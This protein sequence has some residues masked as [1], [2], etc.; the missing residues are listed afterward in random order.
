MSAGQKRLERLRRHL[1][2]PTQQKR[3]AHMR[4]VEQARLAARVVMFG[5][6]SGRILHRHLVAGERHHAGAE[7]EMKRMKRRARERR[8]AAV[9][10][11]G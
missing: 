4:D 1:M 11:I 7:R 6:D 9:V 8:S 2:A 10:H 5:Q 3:L